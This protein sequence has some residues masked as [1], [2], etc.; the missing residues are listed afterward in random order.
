MLSNVAAKLLPVISEIPAVVGATGVAA[1]LSALAISV[2]S[3]AFLRS[4]SLV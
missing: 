2:N 4:N 1:L 3:R